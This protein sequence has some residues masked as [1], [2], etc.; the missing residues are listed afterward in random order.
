MQGYRAKHI[1][2]K[3]GWDL[4]RLNVHSHHGCNLKCSGCSH[5]SE[6]IHV[7]ESIDIDEMI[8]SLGILLDKVKIGHIAVMGGEPMLNPEGTKKIC[9]F[10]ISRNQTLK[11]VTNGYKIDKH[12]DWLIDLV[13][14]GMVVRIS[15]HLAPVRDRGGIKNFHEI[16]V[17]LKK[18]IE[19]GIEVRESAKMIEGQDHG[20]VECI[21]EWKS[22]WYNLFKIDGD[23]VFP[24]NSDKKNAFDVCEF[25]CPQLY[26][27][28]IYKCSHSAYFQDYLAIKNQLK[29]YEW[30]PYIHEHGWDVRSDIE[31]KE[32]LN[33]VYEPENICSSCPSPDVWEKINH[34]QDE[35]IVK[36][37]IPLKE[38]I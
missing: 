17:F 3:L 19:F 36:K 7:A 5:H 2:D 10:L 22:V 34:V 6:L 20:W 31:L 30:Q 14:Q 11:L 29:D 24:Y 38:I 18:C 21:T 32:F 33:N 4:E 12:T 13:R 1:C 15:S 25:N 9:Q 27:G 23:R 8:N 26:N 16:N 35:N 37:K 28:R